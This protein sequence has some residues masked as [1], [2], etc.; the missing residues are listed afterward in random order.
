[1]HWLLVNS[2]LD[3]KE[4]IDFHFHGNDIGERGQVSFNQ[5]MDN[6]PFLFCFAIFIKID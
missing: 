5:L 3:R 6:L 4:N 2:Y 1:M